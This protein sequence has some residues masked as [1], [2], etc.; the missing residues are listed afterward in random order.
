LG[1]KVA[2]ADVQEQQLEAVGKQLT[3]LLGEGNVLVIPTDV[4]KI[5]EVVSLKDRVYEAWGEVN[6]HIRL[7]RTLSAYPSSPSR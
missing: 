2:I 5:E 1:L 3:S 6:L 4:S 7:P